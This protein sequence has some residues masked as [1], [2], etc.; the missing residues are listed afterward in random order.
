MRTSGSGSKTRNCHRRVVDATATEEQLTQLQTDI[1]WELF[2]SHFAHHHRSS[3][4]FEGSDGSEAA[5]TFDG[6]FRVESEAEIWTAARRLADMQR[7]RAPTSAPAPALAPA[8]APASAPPVAAAPPQVF[9]GRDDGSLII[10]AKTQSLR[11]RLSRAVPFEELFWRTEIIPYMQPREGV[12]KKELR[13]EMSTEEEIRAYE[14]RKA[15]QTARMP[16]SQQHCVL[17]TQYPRRTLTG[18]IVRR[19]DIRRLNVGICQ[20]ELQCKRRTANMAFSNCF[21]LYLRWT[22]DGGRSFE[23]SHIKVFPTGQVDLPGIAS[24]VACA[25]IREMLSV[26]L[27]DEP[28]SEEK[29]KEKEKEKDKEKEKGSGSGSSLVLINTDFRCNFEIEREPLRDVLFYKHQLKSLTQP[30]QPSLRCHLYVRRDLPFEVGTQTFV[31]DAEDEME[32]QRLKGNR[33]KQFLKQLLHTKYYKLTCTF[34]RTGKVLVAGAC[35][36]ESLQ[37]VF[38]FVRDLL[39]REHAQIRS[40]DSRPT[41]KKTRK[42]HYVSKLKH[43]V[44]FSYYL[45]RILQTD[46]WV[47]VADGTGAVCC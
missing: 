22:V 13:V 46:P 11:L 45:S 8:S 2:Q 15:A 34:F 25:H 18:A 32:I 43:V 28:P 23:E 12:V 14:A 17:E 7:R 4:G 5:T 19:R 38:E 47:C 41:C 42:T 36:R 31:M 1:E 40:A 27:C 44:D 39:L 9:T 37:F 16:D 29:E 26:L 30:E 24:P 10:S 35:T 6:E 33:R 20:K 21:V 3:L